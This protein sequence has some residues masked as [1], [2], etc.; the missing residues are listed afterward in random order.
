ME[1]DFDRWNKKKKKMELYNHPLSFKE[2]DIWWIGM[3]LN[4]GSEMNGKN[5]LY[6]R[7]VYVLRKCNQNT[8]IGIPCTSKKHNGSHMYSLIIEN[9]GIFHLN[10]SQIRVFSSKRLF[11]KIVKTNVVKDIVEIFIKYLK[12]NTAY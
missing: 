5:A 9:K 6:E 3:G 10:F 7:P 2:G 4:I 12:R 8:F 11:R 1:K